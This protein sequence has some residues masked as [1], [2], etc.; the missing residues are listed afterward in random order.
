MHVWR[1]HTEIIPGIEEIIEHIINLRPMNV[2]KC[3]QSF[4]EIVKFLSFKH[5]KHGNMNRIIF[6][7]MLPLAES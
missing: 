7:L 6:L 3:L 2:K 5:D 1:A 4:T